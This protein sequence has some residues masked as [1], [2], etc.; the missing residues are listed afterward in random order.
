LSSGE[1]VGLVADEPGKDLELKTF[2]SKIVREEDSVP[3]DDLPVISDVNK[4]DIQREFITVK[5]DIHEMVR[6]GPN[7]KLEKSSSPKLNDNY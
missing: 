7:Y 6:K 3:L 1:F 4:E 2:H 5:S